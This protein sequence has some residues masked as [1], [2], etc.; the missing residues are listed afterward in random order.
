MDP[1]PS[2]FETGIDKIRNRIHNP[3]C[4]LG[5]GGPEKDKEKELP[6][7]NQEEAQAANDNILLV[8]T[9]NMLNRK[10]AIRLVK[11]RVGLGFQKTHLLL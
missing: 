4:N 2:F 10:V 7:E 3:A 9:A 1:D 8:N 11:G 6:L 5:G